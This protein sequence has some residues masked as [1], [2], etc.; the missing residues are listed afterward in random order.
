M[1]H[2]LVHLDIVIFSFINSHHAPFFDRFFVLVTWLGN[3]WVAIPVAAAALIIFTP[4]SILAQT[5]LVAATAGAM[6]GFCNTQIKRI[7]D[8]PR[9]LA[10]FAAS[11]ANG[12][13]VKVHVLGER[14]RQNSFPSGHTATAFAAATIVFLLFKRKNFLIFIPAFVVAYARVYAGAHFPLDIAGGAFL[15]CCIPVLVIVFFRRRIFRV[16]SGNVG[17]RV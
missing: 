3:G 12:D 7:I 6:T 15:G 1:F 9:P 10:Y 2:Y 11:S 13:P 17:E 8:R 16:P 14:L 5:L 4:R